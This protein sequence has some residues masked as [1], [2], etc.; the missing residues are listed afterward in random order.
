MTPS[1]LQKLPLTLLEEFLLLGLDDQSGQMHPLAR[2]TLDCAAAG[3][4]LMDLT[5][6]N[7][8]DN[9][10]RDMFVVDGTPTGDALLDPVLQLMSLAPI[11]TPNPIGHWLRQMAAEGEALREK[12]LRRLEARGIIMRQDRKILWMFGTRRYPLIDDKEMR[13]VK[14]RILGVVL[15]NDVPTPHDIMLTGLA[16]AC[17]LF[18]Y[19]LSAH[20]ADSAT[21]RISQ[22]A[23]MDLIGQ[24]VAKGVTEIEAAIA[25]ASGY[26]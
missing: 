12:A 13:E 6:R 20:E 18:R 21:A 23:R 8:I 15:V 9:D 24:A 5:L 26:R 14:L 16:E 17:G 22:V 3:A 11:L 19:I 7:R 2:S 1:E 25:M 4:V 10:L